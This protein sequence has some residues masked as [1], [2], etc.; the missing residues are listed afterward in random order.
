MI[1]TMV[2]FVVS[3]MSVAATVPQ[4][5]SPGDT[6]AMIV[7]GIGKDPEDRLVRDGIIHDLSVYLLE[8]VSVKPN[9]LTVLVAGADDAGASTADRIAEVVRVHASAMTAADRF[10]FYYAGQANAIGDSLRFNLPGPDVTQDDLTR[11]LASI[12]AG[13]Q[14]VVL[15]CPHAA[16]ATRALARPGRVVVLAS[17]AEQAHATRFGTHFVPALTRVE[18]DAN[19]DGNVSVLEAFATAAREIEKWYQDRQILP[20]ETP[21]MED[22]GDGRP[23]ERPWRY[24]QDGGDGRLAAGLVL[25]ARGTG[26]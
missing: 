13:T 16:L 19:R 23:A 14:L 22:N 11:W 4:G 21:C 15:D 18:S 7:S 5:P 1:L 9:H 3:M 20:T 6:Y 24:E 10:V 26:T 17:T 25:A 2:A 8:K 12:Q